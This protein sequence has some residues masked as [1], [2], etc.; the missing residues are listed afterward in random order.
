[1]SQSI[2]VDYGSFLRSGRAVFAVVL[3][4]YLERDRPADWAPPDRELTEYL[5]MMA[6]HVIDLRRGLDYVQTR[7]DLDAGRIAYMS[8]SAGGI[9]MAL[10]AIERRYGAA[11]FVGDGVGKWDLRGHP[12][13]SG[14]N[15]A[16]LIGAPKLLAHGRYDESFPL[17][18]VA[19]PLYN[20]LQEPKE[21]MIV[22]EGAH[23]PDPEFLVPTVSKWLDREFGAVQPVANQ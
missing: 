5:E 13:V 8:A 15:F 3:R 2:E 1:V 18:S 9:L 10:P 12:A 21:P 17:K 7:N 16:P 20:L 19:E 11:I 6:E 22:W 4:G 14:I 23:R